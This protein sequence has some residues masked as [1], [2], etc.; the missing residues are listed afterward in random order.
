MVT[1][2]PDKEPLKPEEIDIDKV[3]YDMLSG[4]IR[5]DQLLYSNNRPKSAAE[6]DDD[7]L[8]KLEMMKSK[9]KY[10][11]KLKSDKRLVNSSGIV[12]YVQEHGFYCSQRLPDAINDI[13]I[14][15]IDEAIGRVYCLPGRMERIT[16]RPSDL[17]LI[18][19]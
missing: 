15:L 3:R 5:A 8:L 9:M 6:I 13:V 7:L 1:K 17:P 14:R 19:R 11:R 2:I 10:T 18:L 16:I 12:R 4:Q